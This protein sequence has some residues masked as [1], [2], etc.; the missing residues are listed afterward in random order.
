MSQHR[1]RV[2]ATLCLVLGLLGAGLTASGVWVH[3]KAELAQ[4]LLEH[5][6]QQ[7]LAG[8]S[9]VKPWPW[10]D[11]WPVARMQVPAMD[12][13]FIVLS[14]GA[15]NALAFGPSHQP[16]SAEPGSGGHVILGGHRDTHF[17][18]LSRLESGASIRI[19][20]PGGNWRVYRA[21]IFQT[22]DIRRDRLQL[23][24]EGHRLT[25]VTCYPFDALQA[26]GPLRYVV[27]AFPD[28]IQAGA[29]EAYTET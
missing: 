12:L 29:G 19:Q 7:T 22:A 4:I 2:I 28:V 27:D 15:G 23:D 9:D 17:R 8:H 11:T 5:A 20:G 21:S 25:L 13:D 6:W 18:F 24:E 3:A 1:P 26:G 14:G 10:A 16:D